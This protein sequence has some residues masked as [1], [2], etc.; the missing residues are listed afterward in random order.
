MKKQSGFTLI[1]GL[2]ILVI[3]GLLGGTGWYVWNAHNKANDTLTN[4]DAANS[5][6]ARK[7]AAR[8][9]TARTTG[10]RKRAARRTP[11]ARKRRTPEVSAPEL[12]PFPAERPQE[13]EQP[14]VGPGKEEVPPEQT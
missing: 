2:L 6:T 7:T 10:T 11:V 9:T 13:E 8:R 5:S 12:L 4:A 1:E 3:V 14:E